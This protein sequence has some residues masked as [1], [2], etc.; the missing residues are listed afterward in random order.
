MYVAERQE[1][2]LEKYGPKGQNQMTKTLEV[3]LKE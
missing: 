1:S 3:Y 2:Q